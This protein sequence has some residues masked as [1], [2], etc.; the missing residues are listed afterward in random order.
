[1]DYLTH[2]GITY[3]ITV[4]ALA[5]DDGFAVEL[6]DL[7]SDGGVLA[8]VRVT[9]NGVTLIHQEP[10]PGDVYAWWTDAVTRLV[11]EH[12]IDEATDG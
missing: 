9:H 6:A 12:V 5:H 2:A 4:L 11:K 10:L 3:E 1:M 8:E 7:S